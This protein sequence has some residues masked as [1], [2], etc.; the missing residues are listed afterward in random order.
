M[1]PSPVRLF[2]LLLLLSLSACE[3]P[4]VRYEEADSRAT[5][6]DKETLA[7]AR[8]AANT[9]TV[10]ELEGP[11]S[12]VSV[13]LYVENLTSQ[14]LLLSTGAVRLLDGTGQTLQRE[15]IEP[16]KGTNGFAIPPGGTRRFDMIFAL[17]ETARPKYGSIPDLILIWR[18]DQTH[19][20][21]T[22]RVLLFEDWFDDTGD[23]C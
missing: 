1:N 5:T 4:P 14:D 9:L 17:P 10:E 21:A 15:R 16:A 8:V 6:D 7:Y 11:R 23:G 20:F 12:K 22:A 3:A 13:R 18:V 2:R 19:R